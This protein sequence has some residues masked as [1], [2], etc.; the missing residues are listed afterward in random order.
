MSMRLSPSAMSGDAARLQQ[1]LNNL[2]GNALKFTERGEILMEAYPL[3]CAGRR[4]K[5]RVL[6]AVTDT[7]I[8]IGGGQG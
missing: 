4:T 5:V 6:F 1:V 7:G 8:G 3:P 2:V